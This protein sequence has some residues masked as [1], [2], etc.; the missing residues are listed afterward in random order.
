MNPAVHVCAEVVK[1]ANMK[2][3]SPAS[4]MAA[5]LSAL[6]GQS[7]SDALVRLE[8]CC[9]VPSFVEACRA[10]A[11]DACRV[12]GPRGSSMPPLHVAASR[13]FESCVQR[14]LLLGASSSSVIEVRVSVGSIRA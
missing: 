14:M 9:N 1:F 12:K 13:G 4:L 5:F 8:E 3:T 11:L 7:E 6:A 10:G 2:S